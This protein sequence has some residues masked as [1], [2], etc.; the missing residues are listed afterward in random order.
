MLNLH[1]G[2]TPLY[3]AAFDGH[4]EV[5]RLL[6]KKGANVESSVLD[7]AKRNGHKEIVELLGGEPQESGF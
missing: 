6:L 2:C 7:I 4:L 1:D 3:I 5:V